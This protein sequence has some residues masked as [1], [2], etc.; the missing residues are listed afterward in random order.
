MGAPQLTAHSIQ[1]LGGKAAPCIF[2][3]LHG[4]AILTVG[5]GV[6]LARYFSWTAVRE[7]SYSC[8]FPNGDPY[9]GEAFKVWYHP[10]PARFRVREREARMVPAASVG[11]VG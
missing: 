1:R 5:L 8:V 3:S 9:K 7:L 11:C 10:E 2:F 4:L 6:A